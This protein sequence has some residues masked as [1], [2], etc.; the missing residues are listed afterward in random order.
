MKCTA[1]R[2]RWTSFGSNGPEDAVAGRGRRKTKG[3]L[4]FR[5]VADPSTASS[6]CRKSERSA[7]LASKTPAVERGFRPTK[8]TA[9]PIFRSS[10]VNSV[11]IAPPA[12]RIV[13]RFS[14]EVVESSPVIKSRSVKIV[15]S[16]ELRAGVGSR[17]NRNDKNAVGSATLKRA[18]LEFLLA[19]FSTIF[20]HSWSD[21]L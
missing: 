6:A 3:G 18:F 12:P 8:R 19:I 2:K 10:R 1:L 4:D 14:E 13:C 17:R 20:Q 21:E 15:S 7:D 9:L 16:V 11:A 5:G